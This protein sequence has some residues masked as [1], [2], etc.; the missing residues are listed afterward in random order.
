[1]VPP[2][3][4]AA[5]LMLARALTVA[6]PRC[7]ARG[8]FLS[9]FRLRE[10][11]PRCALPLERGEQR[12]YWLGGMMFNIGLSELLAVLTV[13]LAIWAS[14]PEVAWNAIWVGAILLMIAAPF[15]LF[16]VSRIV[17][18]AFDMIFRPHHD[19]HYR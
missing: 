3:N 17:W 8:L 14:Y 9:W 18:L 19:S 5:L 6:C 16:P 4:P 2:R 7:G 11:C 12:D 15:L 13:G 10:R 1:M